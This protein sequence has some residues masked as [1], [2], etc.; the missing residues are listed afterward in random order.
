MVVRMSAGTFIQWKG[1]DVC[2]DFYCECGAHGHLDSDFAYY[3][4]CP[5]CG[6]RYELGTEVSAR[7]LAKGEEANTPPR[8]LHID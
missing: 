8:R 2:L 7:R 3:V 1:T 5:K 6:A 4:E